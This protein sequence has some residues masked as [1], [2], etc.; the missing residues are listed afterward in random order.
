MTT[1]PKGKIFPYGAKQMLAST[2]P[3]IWYTSP[4]GAPTATGI[5]PG[6]SQFYL[7]GGAV[8][9]PGITD[10]LI[11]KEW[12]DGLSPSFKHLDLSG[13]HQ[14]GTTWQDT[15]YDPMEIDFDLEAHARTPQG[16]SACVAEW[17]GAWDPKKQGT[18]E[19]F[20]LDT[21]YWFC[22]PRLFK[23]WK[24]KTKKTPRL[25][26]KQP[27]QHAMRVDDAFWKSIDSTSTFQPGGTGGSGFLPIS[28][29]GS[30]D[31]WVRILFYGPGTL[32]IANGPGSTDM[33]T[34]GP[35]LPGQI[36]LITTEPRLRSV[37]DL[38]P[39]LPSTGQ[40]N[41]MQNLMTQLFSLAFNS[42]TPPLL[43][44]FESLFGILPPQG[45]MYSLL[46]GRFT[47][48]VPGVALPSWAQTQHIACS[49]TGGTS[50]SKIVC[51]LTPQRVWAEGA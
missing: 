45:P 25:T 48:P 16:L 19:Y 51:A 7:H 33:I 1:Y 21:G 31:G 10:G 18:L 36:A 50:A 30:V 24:G 14:D 26:L 9:W 38:S 39:N 4:G 2:L 17:V 29:I 43:S 46:K 20:T 41:L 12:P 22:N 13:A 15:V 23:V 40:T 6:Q 49:I 3:N 28:N 34:F 37:V 8:A 32:A 27:L 44:W 11:C 5:G 47:N 42:N 35:L